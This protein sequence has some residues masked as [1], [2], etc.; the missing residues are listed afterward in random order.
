[1]AGGS[2][3]ATRR[4]VEHLAVVASR[5]EILAGGGGEGATRK[6]AGMGGRSPV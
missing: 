3:E 1:V 4:L 2:T 5:A 6:G